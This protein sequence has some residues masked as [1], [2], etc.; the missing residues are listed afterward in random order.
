MSHGVDLVT[1]KEFLGHSSISTTMI[2]SHL[3]TQHKIN[4]IEK[5]PWS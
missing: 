2:Y 5:L 1:V 4:S 3:S